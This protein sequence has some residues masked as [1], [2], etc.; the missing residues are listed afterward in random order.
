M[1]V[2]FTKRFADSFRRLD[3]ATKDRV[4][5]AITRFQVDHTHPGLRFKKLVGAENYTIRATRSSRIIRRQLS[6]DEYELV[7]V[8]HHDVLRRY[9]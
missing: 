9:G 2:T 3:K 6:R 7:D 8:G 4:E 5:E 1:H